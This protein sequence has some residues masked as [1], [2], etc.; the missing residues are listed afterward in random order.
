MASS[1]TVEH[2][3]LTQGVGGSSPPSPAKSNLSE[4]IMSLRT[5]IYNALFL[6]LFA[7]PSQAG[8]FVKKD[9]VTYFGTTD[10]SLTCRWDT[11]EA[12]IDEFELRLFH[13]ER[14]VETPIA[15]GKTSQ[16]E[17]TFK[18]PRTGHFIVKVRACERDYT[19]CSDWSES[20]DPEV[21]TVDGE[22]R[23]WWV[24][25]HVAAP[26]ELNFGFSGR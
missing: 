17:L 23:G 12:Y 19:F 7:L 18:L 4:A 20:I 24:Y 1:S 3:A 9:L 26:G 10:K 25:G 5:M 13:V 14:D 6:V 22:P 21:A 11:I 2:L 15:N 8:D 16:N